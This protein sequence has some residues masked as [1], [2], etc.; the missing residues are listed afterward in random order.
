[1]ALEQK[2]GDDRE[3]ERLVAAR[4]N[5]SFTKRK[6][7]QQKLRAGV[8]ISRIDTPDRIQ[9]RRRMLNKQFA[10]LKH[11]ITES[12]RFFE[13]AA[14]VAEEE[15][16]LERIIQKSNFVG[17]WFFELG[18]ART[19]AVCCIRNDRH[20][21]FGTGFMV[22]PSLMLTNAHVLP[23]E[24]SA[25]GCIAEF[26]YEVD[27]TSIPRTTQRFKIRPD[28][29]FVSSP[30]T[31]LDFAL[32]NV[33]PVS[34]Q[35][36][37]LKSYGH[38][39]LI[40]TVGK[41][42]LGEWL[43]II[44][45]PDGRPKEVALRDN[46]LLAVL[47]DFLHY[48]TDTEPGSSGSPVFNDQWEVVCLHHKGVAKT[49]PKTGEY[50]LKDGSRVKELTRDNSYLIDWIGNEG[51]RISKIVPKVW[52]EARQK[53]LTEEL[54]G[55]PRDGQASSSTVSGTGESNRTPIGYQNKPNNNHAQGA[56]VSQNNQQVQ[57][58]T[59]DGTVTIELPLRISISIG[60]VRVVGAEKP[61]NCGDSNKSSATAKIT[62]VASVESAL[63]MLEAGRKRTYYNEAVDRADAEM[64]YSRLSSTRGNALRRELQ[65]LI[66][67]THTTKPSYDVSRVK[68]LY[69]WV[70]L[71][72][73]GQVRS[74]YSDQEFDPAEF[75]REDFEI[76]ARIE[77]RLESRG[78][79]D[80]NLESLREELEA[81]EPFNCEHVVPQSW[82]SKSEPMRGDLHH[83]HSC[84]SN[85][86]SF[87]GNQP[88]KDFS[89]FDEAEGLRPRCG[90]AQDRCFEP[91]MG[92][93]KVA[94]SVLYFML[95]YEGKFNATGDAYDSDGIATI[96]DWS[97]RYPVTEHEKHRNQAIFEIQGNRNPFIDRPDWA[98]EVFG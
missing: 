4:L 55:F 12:D 94:R 95:R 58:T 1:M 61:C 40:A 10:V 89:K 11:T 2:Q 83:L 79:S 81:R 24:A 46:Q 14:D 93:G 76:E 82:F 57:V 17:T 59:N 26:G 53:N 28:V 35:G 15:F 13:T 73:N 92:K 7:V 63:R 27:V 29:F 49:D 23:D 48:E 86:N 71:Q 68:H 75:I 50:L 56:D 62:S 64:Y 97:N 41:A 67:D 54:D 84:E 31:K 91:F 98:T 34:Q 8:P 85:C 25:T 47:D 90:F 69:A 66:T 65:R 51:V 20:S 42:I 16:G 3:L 74:I 5:S 32:V 21:A 45:H 52:E 60:D 43:N 78:G 44:Q 6:E 96:I 38:I 39:P 30:S 72:R 19:R 33:E 36:A 80:A 88:Y 9:A 77:T 70:D 22:T 37:S 87:R 18:V